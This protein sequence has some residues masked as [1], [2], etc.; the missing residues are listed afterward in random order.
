MIWA[1]MCKYE[2]NKRAVAVFGRCCP[3]CLCQH[4]CEELFPDYYGHVIDFIHVYDE[5]MK[6]F[7]TAIEW[8]PE[9]EARLIDEHLE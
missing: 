5:D 8:L 2:N 4:Y 6:Q 9:E 3:F 1:T 7:G